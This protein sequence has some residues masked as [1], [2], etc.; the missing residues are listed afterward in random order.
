M[1]Y[2]EDVLS[3][4]T[5][6]TTENMGDK[7]K[8]MVHTSCSKTGMITHSLLLQGQPVQPTMDS[9]TEDLN[10]TIEKQHKEVVRQLQERY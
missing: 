9:Q 1:V 7:R 2:F 8:K 4:R 3:E 6:E 10:N 5:K